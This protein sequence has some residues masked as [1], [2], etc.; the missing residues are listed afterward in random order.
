MPQQFINTGLLTISLDTGR[1]LSSAVVTKIKY[2]KPNGIGGEW[3]ASV[4]GTSLTYDVSNTDIDVPG[5]WQFQAYVEIDGEIGRG[6][7]VT[8]TFQTPL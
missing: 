7:I 4:S 8:Q 6:E 3:A 1:D 2:I 5:T